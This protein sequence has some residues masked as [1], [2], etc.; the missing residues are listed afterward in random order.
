MMDSTIDTAG[1]GINIWDG[2][3]LDLTATTIS[4]ASDG[5]LDYGGVS[6]HMDKAQ[7]RNNDSG[8]T[9]YPDD[10]LPNS[11]YTVSHS[12]ISDNTYDGIY[13]GTTYTVDFSKTYW[14]DPS[15]PKND[16]TNLLGLGNAV[17]DGVIFDPWSKCDS[18]N[19]KTP[20]LIVPGVL[21]TEMS[22]QTDSG[23]EKLWLD[24][25]HT[26]TDWGDEFMD[27]LQFTKDLKPTNDAISLGDIIRKKSVS[28]SDDEII[29]FDYAAHLIDEFENQGYQEGTDLF[30][31][32]Y[33]WRYG[34]NDDTIAKLK[35]KITDIMIETGSDKVDVVAH[36]TGGL[37]VKKYAMDYPM[38]NHIGKA[39]FV[40]VPNTGAP[41]A[42]KVLLSG[43]SFSVPLLAQSEMKK[44]AQ[45]FP[46]VYDLSPSKAYYDHKGSY[47]KV[48]NQNFFAETSHDLDFDE[49]NDFL[50]TDHTLNSG[51]VAISQELHTAEFDDF[52][53]RSAGIDLYAI[54]GC[55][56]GTIG[57]IKEVRYATLLGGT[58]TDYD[59]PEETPGD[60]TVPLESATNLPITED[61]KYYALKADHAQM[62]SQDGIRQEIVNMLAGTS[63]ST[64]SSSGKDLITQ[65][66]NACKLNGHAISIYSPL[67]IDI[68]DADGNHAGPTSGGASTENTIPNADYELM[69]DHKFVY[70]PTDDGQ[71]YTISLK[72]T[73]T[74]VFTLTDATIIDNA[75]TQTQ[76]F[77]KVSV[78][79]ALSGSFALDD[80][81]STLSLDT[82]GG[83]AVD[84]T[85]FPTK[86]LSADE[87][88]NYSPIRVEKSETVETFDGSSPDTSAGFAFANYSNPPPLTDSTQS[89]QSI[90]ELAVAPEKAIVVATPSIKEIPETSPRHPMNEIKGV[91]FSN[92]MPAIALTSADT[93]NRPIFVI[94]GLVG[95]MVLFFLGRYLIKR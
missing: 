82:D 9:I 90:P 74:G 26:I 15:G 29:F 65:D 60:G 83:G 66:I 84:S 79:E 38:D 73:G 51:A 53:M 16:T 47:V 33:D 39:V 77:E 30:I 69:G 25:E 91:S 68:V 14:G 86:T 17:S 35:Q 88:Q 85:L 87:S 10:S 78:T 71:T 34:V 81:Q 50:I 19:C 32:P 23:P 36:S 49:T 89:I 64:A 4:H 54:D 2:V 45:N 5:V 63:L 28:V 27:S 1:E 57:K 22:K 62:M 37:L 12:V 8:I 80:N 41:K 59:S 52:D 6:V 13:N 94:V 67:S 40:G 58:E 56:T 43:D 21:G 44:L 48:I 18:N 75:V 95:F 31:L 72:G 20:V 76:V 7:I 93:S 70:L 42:I 11:M 46:V 55:K 61:H 92:S 24:I 3:T